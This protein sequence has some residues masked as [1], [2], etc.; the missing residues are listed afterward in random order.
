[1]DHRQDNVDQGSNEGIVA[2]SQRNLQ[3]WSLS[4]GKD[5]LQ[6]SISTRVSSEVRD[7]SSIYLYEGPELESYVNETDTVT[8]IIES[9]VSIE[10]DSSS[11]SSLGGLFPVAVFE[12][13]N[14]LL[15]D[16]ELTLLYPTALA[17]AGLDRFQR[18]FARFLKRYSQNLRE[19]ACSEIQ[20][21]AAQFVRIAASRTAA[22]MGHKLTQID[23]EPPRLQSLE[24]EASKAVL[25][26]RW[27]ELTPSNELLVTAGRNNLDDHPNEFH[28]ESC[29]QLMSFDDDESSDEDGS[30]SNPLHTLIEVKEFMVS[31]QAFVD[32]RREFRAWLKLDAREDKTQSDRDEFVTSTVNQEP[33]MQSWW[34]QLMNIYSPPALGYY[35]IPYICGCGEASYIDVKELSPGGLKRFR[36][37]LLASA[38]AVRARPQGLGGSS[39]PAQPPHAHMNPSPRPAGVARNE[40]RQT[41][42]LEQLPLLPYPG[43]SQAVS[44]VYP[45]QDSQYLLLCV[46]TRKSTVLV[47]VDLGSVFSDEYLF[48]QIRQEYQRV[49]EQHEWRI[50]KAVPSC[51]RK[52]FIKVSAR[53]PSFPPLPNFLNYLSVVSHAVRGAHLHKIASGDYVR[54]QLIPIGMDC[55]PGW[56]KTGQFPP[57]AEVTAKRYMYEPVPM[58]VEIADIPLPHLLKP[59]PHFDNFWLT[60][61]PK[62]VRDQLVRRPGVDGQR[63]IGWGVRVNEGPNW[64]VFLLSILVILLAIGAGVI[65]YASLTSDNSSAFGLGA[66]LAAFVTVYLNYQYF[67]W[68]EDF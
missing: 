32:L 21:Q 35:R 33:Q 37:R 44:N 11:K 61:F 60:M 62:K 53:L 34:L 27:L 8:S 22:A 49:R 46:N 20:H 23:E 12:L 66:F 2:V 52:F 18:N 17:R 16:A 68:K 56:F 63:V 30:M 43:E 26:P 45:S 50:V 19:E 55:C 54:F 7:T 58:G 47:H 1:M 4:G 57:I 48:Q 38:A 29:S 40:G 42:S 14:L 10:S 67:A 51:I 39:Q 13:V 41:V 28:T 15:N 3:G 6:S 31:A 24:S 36:Q 5:L 59:G 25:I 65:V 64:V 9:I